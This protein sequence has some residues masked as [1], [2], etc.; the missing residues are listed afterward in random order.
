MSNTTLSNSQIKHKNK[1]SAVLIVKNEAAN[2]ERCLKSLS[3]AGEIVVLDTGSTDNTVEICN[4]YT[5]KI[6]SLD[7][8]EGF[9]KAKQIAVNYANNDWI[10]SVD[11]DEEIT[12]ELA[13]KIQIILNNP[14]YDAYAIK[15][16][17]FY[18]GK[19]I[20]HSGWNK[21]YPKR[22]FN[23]QKAGFNDAK[24]HESVIVNG[25]LG[26][27]EETILHYTYPTINSHIQKIILYSELS[28]QSSKKNS[29]LF[30]AILR[31]KIKFFKMYFLQLGFL[32]GREGLIL[33]IISSF[34]VFTKY[35]KIW[36]RNIND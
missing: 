13:E 6:Y 10:L 12:T 2:I 17:S 34:S 14:D 32:D 29:N 9:G 30:I 28:A 3:F 27:I 11:A 31:G 1:L 19:M 20:K 15:R 4:K 26:T 23:K 25:K 16:N 24:V 21:D 7:K 36:E 35:L 8:W 5:D 18:L 22:L 33:A